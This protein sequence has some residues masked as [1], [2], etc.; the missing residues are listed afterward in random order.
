MSETQLN[1]EEQRQARQE[2][3]AASGVVGVA[4]AERPEITASSTDNFQADPLPSL[5]QDTPPVKQPDLMPTVPE[6][7]GSEPTVVS[8]LARRMHKNLAEYRSNAA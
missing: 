6:V 1:P 5:L 7:D 3:E 2:V 8:L 4:G